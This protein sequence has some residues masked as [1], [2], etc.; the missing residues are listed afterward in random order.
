MRSRFPSALPAVPAVHPRI[1]PF[2]LALLTI[3]V[4]LAAYQARPAPYG[5]RFTVHARVERATAL[6]LHTTK[7]AVT[8]YDRETGGPRW[9]HTRPGHRPLAVLPARV[10]TIALWEDGL[11]TATDGD[12][13]R[14]HRALPNAGAWLA[15]HG[16]TGVLRLLDPRMLAVVTPDRVTAY[17]VVDGD[18]RWV[19]PAHRGCAFAPGRA[20]RHGTTLLLA[21]PCAGDSDASWTSQLVPV[22]D[23]GRV[24]PHR[25]PLGNELP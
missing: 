13:V 9:T 8:A 16:G 23:L 10:R 11:V 24:T 15:D 6:R 21:Q 1:P 22:D 5:D 14:W 3:P 19:L 2:L 20:A 25:R 4:L 7:G 18:L 12:T 17:R